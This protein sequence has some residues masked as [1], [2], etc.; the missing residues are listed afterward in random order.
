[1]IR[2]QIIST[3][4]GW[5]GT[6]YHHHA[7]IKG[8]GVDC[9]QFLIAVYAECDLLPPVETGYYAQD[10]HLHK[11][12]EIYLDGIK[13]NAVETLSIQTGDIALFTFGRCVSH[14][15]IFLKQPEK[16][17]H[18]FAGQGVIISD[19]NGQELKGRFHSAWTVL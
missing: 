13:K 16:I 7:R 1:M 14:A 6:P 10:W 5:L 11:S 2:D 3:A 17:I 19:I 12:G 15:G 4:M 8:V 18:A 9:V